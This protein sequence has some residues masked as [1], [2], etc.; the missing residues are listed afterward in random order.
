MVPSPSCEY[1]EKQAVIFGRNPDKC[2]RLTPYH[3]KI[4]DAAKALCLKNPELL[5]DC[6]KLLELSREKDMQ[7]DTSTIKVCPE[8]RGITLM[9]AKKHQNE[10][11]YLRM[12]N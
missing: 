2:S 10:E 12:F 11:R 8:A 6:A 7:T 9:C 3:L 5:N 1:I 4:N